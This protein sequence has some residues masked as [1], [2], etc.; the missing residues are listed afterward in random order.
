MRIL[1]SNLKLGNDNQKYGEGVVCHFQ[2]NE[3][4]TNYFEGLF[5]KGQ[6]EFCAQIRD[7]LAEIIPVDVNQLEL[8]VASKFLDGSFYFT[9]KINHTWDLIS[10]MNTKKILQTLDDMSKNRDITLVSHLSTTMYQAA[11]KYIIINSFFLLVFF[12]IF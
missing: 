3:K 5:Q 10:M 1:K 4:G 11:S 6:M 9:M 2:L 8:P 7:E 12:I